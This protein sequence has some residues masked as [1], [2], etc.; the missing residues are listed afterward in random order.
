MKDTSLYTLPIRYM[1]LFSILI[2]FSGL[3]LFLL[4]PT[5]KSLHNLIEIATPHILAMGILIFTLAH[6]LLFSTKIKRQS[7]RNIS[8]WLYGFMFVNIFASFFMSF[9]WIKLLVLSGFVLLFLLL[10]AMLWVSL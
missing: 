1:I 6:F 2:L 4:S 5:E 3:W 10:L 9:A 7:S 8:K